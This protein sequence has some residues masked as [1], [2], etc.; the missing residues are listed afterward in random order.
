MK[1]LDNPNTGSGYTFDDPEK[2]SSPAVP[3]GIL[4]NLY[5]N[6][7]LN[8]ALDGRYAFGDAP[9][10]S[11]SPFLN[12]TFTGTNGD[13]NTT[14]FASAPS[15][16]R[17]YSTDQ[18]FAPETSSL[19]CDAIAGQNGFGGRL[20][21]PVLPT[22]VEGDRLWLRTY[23]YIPS[24]FCAGYGTSPN[25]GFGSTKWFRIQWG[26]AGSDPVFSRLTLQLGNFTS[27]SCST[28]PTMKYVSLESFG[29]PSVANFP[30]ELAIPQD[31]WVAL[32]FE[33]YFHSTNGY[34][35]GWVGDQYAGQVD[36]NTVPDALVYGL[37]N[38]V[39]GDYWNGS[40]HQNSNF[41]VQDV[42]ATV[43]TPTT[44]DSGGR[45]YISPN[46]RSGDFT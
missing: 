3:T 39:F 31:Q 28:G 2:L 30:T 10:A 15:V 25:D 5:R 46:T 1:I 41:F 12:Y 32:Q 24:S 6:P 22:I 20:N 45:P 23:Q 13:T 37:E 42:I 4:F 17:Y 11:Y 18:A 38:F 29:G 14:E 34:I 43:E 33:V 8:G 40:P 21:N 35:R 19:N 27:G 44:T 7:A 9:A 36:I 16:K 26:Q